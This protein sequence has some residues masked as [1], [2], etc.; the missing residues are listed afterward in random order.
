MQHAPQSAPIPTAVSP[1]PALALVRGVL[2]AIVAVAHVGI[3]LGDISPLILWCSHLSFAAVVGFLVISGYSIGASPQRDAAGFYSRRLRRLVPWYSVALIAGIFVRPDVPLTT[4]LA[5]VF[6]LQGIL[7]PPLPG[8]V[9]LWSLGVEMLCYIVAPVLFR[10]VFWPIAAA[11]VSIGCL[12][13]LPAAG[14]YTFWLAAQGGVAWLGLAWAFCGGLLLQ[15]KSQAALP[16]LGAGICVVGI[17]YGAA[18]ALLTAL[19]LL[20]CARPFYVPR[21]SLAIGDWSYVLY[22]MHLPLMWWLLA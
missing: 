4:A 13:Y 2:A 19:V 7:A 16:L 18:G 15:R 10:K 11:C 20:V 8:N 17:Y 12:A 3:F 9:A 22:V 14:Y 6:F 1:W 5:N 21:W